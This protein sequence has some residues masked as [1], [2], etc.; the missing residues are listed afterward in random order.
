[1]VLARRLGPRCGHRLCHR[2]RLRIHSLLG[3]LGSLSLVACELSALC[4]LV[5]GRSR[6]SDGSDRRICAPP[7]A[8]VSIE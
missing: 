7:N 6:G 4:P 5:A 8:E 3:C 1:M 2:R